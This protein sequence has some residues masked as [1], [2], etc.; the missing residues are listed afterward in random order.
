MQK[1]QFGIL[2][3][4]TVAIEACAV[5]LPFI[6]GYYIYNQKELYNGIQLNE[7]AFCIGNYL[8]IKKKELTKAF[9]QLNKK[10]VIENMILKQKKHL[11]KKSKERFI[12]TFNEL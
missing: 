4:S 5:R 1:S 10:V 7:L 11:D 3:A 9:E 2:P 8:Q 6:C 12:K